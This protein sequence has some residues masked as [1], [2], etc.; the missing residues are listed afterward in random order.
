M[1]CPFCQK[2]MKS[3]DN[4]KPPPHLDQIWV[5]H[6]C[7]QEVR[8][9]ASKN[10]DTESWIIKHVCIFVDYKEK[11]YCMHFSYT[12][13]YFEILDVTKD[14]GGGV[15]IKTNSMPQT[16]NPTNASEKLQIYITFS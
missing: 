6:H 4:G 5:C 1:Q 8:V 9:A 14:A 13:N 15:I 10:P 16:L 3:I 11:T 2:E 7:S 12:G